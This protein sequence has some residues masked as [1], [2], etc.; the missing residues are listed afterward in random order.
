MAQIY[1]IYEILGRLVLT[2]TLVIIFKK[3]VELKLKYGIFGIFG[4]SFVFNALFN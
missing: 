4:G 1:A 3:K 2:E